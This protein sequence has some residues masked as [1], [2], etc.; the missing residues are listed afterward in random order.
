MFDVVWLN[1]G[2]DN[3]S[4]RNC[5]TVNKNIKAINFLWSSTFD[6]LRFLERHRHYCDFLFEVVSEWCLRV[7][8]IFSGAPLNRLSENHIL[9]WQKIWSQNLC[10]DEVSLL[11][12]VHSSI[13]QKDI[14]SWHLKMKTC[15]KK[16]LLRVLYEGI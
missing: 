3:I 8:Q 10:N 13:L 11:S 1:W 15:M 16:C 5:V 7:V 6:K 4:W 2:T 12:D 14:Q 9:T